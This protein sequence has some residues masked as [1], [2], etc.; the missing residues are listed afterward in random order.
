MATVEATTPR[1]AMVLY[2]PMGGATATK[3]MVC[4]VCGQMASPANNSLIQVVNMS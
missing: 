4:T 3:S 2:E 1:Y